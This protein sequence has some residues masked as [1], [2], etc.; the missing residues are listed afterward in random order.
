MK[1]QGEFSRIISGGYC[2]GCGVCAHRAP[3][4]IH[5]QFDRYGMYQAV[6]ETV[7]LD[8]SRAADLLRVCPFSNDGPNEDELAKDLFPE[9]QSDVRFGRYESLYVGSV[10]EGEFRARGSSGGVI[11]WILSELLKKKMVDSVLHVAPA[12]QSGDRLFEY[13]ISTSEKEV[14]QGAKSKYYPVELSQVLNIVKAHEGR[15]VLVGVPCFIKA[16]RRLALIDPV[17]QE[18]IVF[19][20]GL[21]CGHLKSKAFADCIAWQAGITPGKLDAIDFRVKLPEA[22]ASEYG[23]TV[24][25]AGI[26]K[27]AP[28]AGY[29]GAN[30]GYGFF[31]YSACEYCDD[32]FAETADLAVGDAWLPEFTA[33]SRG[34]SVVIARSKE[35]RDLI[36]AAQKEGR[37]SFQNCSAEKMAESQAGG[38][39]H[40]RDGLACRL[41]IKKERNEWIP[42]KR[43]AVSVRGISARRR[44]IYE[45]REVLRKQSHELWLVSLEAADFAVFRTG[46]Q[47]LI[48]RYNRTYVSLFSRIAQKAKRILKIIMQ[49]K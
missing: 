49:V 1:Q 23:V 43:V 25:G 3:D 48:H 13:R 31:K 46:M 10:T 20:V 18:R 27:T 19:Y 28:V 36:D 6:L 34:S 22:R 17:I 4:A 12:K 5:M 42:Q 15:T 14:L 45:L 40:R 39:R 37:V 21:V 9:T 44:K 8:G 29:F 41:C 2:I 26:E 30:W 24:W 35:M 7:G 32:V 33:D 11:S 38:L 47:K 16:V